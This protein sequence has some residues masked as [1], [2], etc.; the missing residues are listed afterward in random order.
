MKDLFFPISE[1][2]M[3][4]NYSFVTTENI[5]KVYT[6]MINWY[7][8]PVMNCWLKIRV[9]VKRSKCIY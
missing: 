2:I 4:R 1:K 7:V 9:V 5:L 3:F 6:S 8:I